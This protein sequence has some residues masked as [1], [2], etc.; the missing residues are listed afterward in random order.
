MRLAVNKGSILLIGTAKN[1]HII[2][3]TNR[4]CLSARHA[5]KGDCDVGALLCFPPH[6]RSDPRGLDRRTDSNAMS[7]ILPSRAMQRGRYFAEFH[8][9]SSLA[10]SPARRERSLG[11]TAGVSG[12]FHSD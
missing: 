11:G 9:W 4:Q 10:S 7:S 1:G 2:F 6:R 12:G 5:Q 3:D 8:S